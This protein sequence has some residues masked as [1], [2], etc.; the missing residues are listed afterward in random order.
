MNSQ[1]RGV[2]LIELLVVVAVVGLL[3]ALIIPAVQSARN[4]ARLTQCKDHLRQVAGAS[5]S[6]STANSGKLPARWL[7]VYSGLDARMDYERIVD[8]ERK[9]KQRPDHIGGSPALLCPSDV[10]SPGGLRVGYFF[11]DGTTTSRREDTPR[12]SNGI[13]PDLKN[14]L[15]IVDRNQS[16]IRDGLSNTTFAAERLVWHKVVRP[17][18]GPPVPERRYPW[19]FTEDVEHIEGLAE[20]HARKTE[21]S[22][23]MSSMPFDPSDGRSGK[24]SKATFSAQAD[25]YTT[26]FDHVL[27]PNSRPMFQFVATFK[28]IS[29]R[30][31]T[32]LHTGG[33]NV[34]FCD[35]H[36]RFVSDDIDPSVWRKLGTR[37]GRE[38]VELP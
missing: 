28:F 27:P 38:V 24:A 18:V 33:I 16:E 26:F 25:E 20:L 15:I 37:A 29:T 9:R 35:G 13:A 5:E 19:G 10:V 12:K 36:I 1:R 31:A 7:D 17:Q 6:Y 3:L 32:S 11:N 30:P 22:W 23:D 34:L 21:W 14:S 2:S 4:A 8:A